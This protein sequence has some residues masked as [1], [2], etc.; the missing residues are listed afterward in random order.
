MPRAAAAARTWI[1]R[2]GA[3][4]DLAGEGFGRARQRLLGTRGNESGQQR[5]DGQGSGDGQAGQVHGRPYMQASCRARAVAGA[6]GVLRGEQLR[7]QAAAIRAARR[8]A[9]Q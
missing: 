8:S 5:G 3:A 7:R 6:A 2:R 9:Q 4:R 1:A